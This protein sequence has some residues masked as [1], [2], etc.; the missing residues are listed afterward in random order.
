MV[1]E[2]E[3]SREDYMNTQLH[4]VSMSKTVRKSLAWQRYGCAAAAFLFGILFGFLELLEGHVPFSF[5]SG[6]LTATIVIWL[7]PKYFNWQMARH[8]SKLLQEA[9][10]T[11]MFGRHT[12]RLLPEGVEVTSPTG[13]YRQNWEAIDRIEQIDKYIHIYAGPL[14][15]LFIPISSFDG[16][17]QL[18]DFLATARRFHSLRLSS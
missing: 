12:T 1:I 18:A 3:V 10:T 6:G 14:S 16:P 11:G 5:F 17:N 4:L 8:C 9:E 13:L 7:Y 2:Y 15:A